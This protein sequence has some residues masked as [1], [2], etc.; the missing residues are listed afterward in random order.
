MEIKNLEKIKDWSINELE[1]DIARGGKFVIYTYTISLIAFTTRRPTDIYYIKSDEHAIGKGWPFLILSFFLGWWG[2][3]WG[4]IYTI[5]SIWYAFAGKNIT[6]EIKDV[7]MLQM[8]SGTP[9]TYDTEKLM[10]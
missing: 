8:Q 10:S 4:P 5:Q 2:I 6:E 1:M 7:A 3:P 9:A